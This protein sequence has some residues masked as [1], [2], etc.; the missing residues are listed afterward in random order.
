[1][2]SY[3]KWKLLEESFGGVLGI[4]TPN[5]VGGI[6][7]NLAG[8]EEAKTKKKMLEDDAVPTDEVPADDDGDEDDVGPVGGEG[9]QRKQRQQNR[10]GSFHYFFSSVNVTSRTSITDA[11]GISSA[12]SVSSSG[13]PGPP[14]T[15]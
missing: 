4:Q 5:V 7:G 3:Q 6:V 14:P 9:R 12:R 10:A 1:M 13:S 2:L 11:P 15:R 8:I